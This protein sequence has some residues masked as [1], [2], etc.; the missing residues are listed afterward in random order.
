ML[1]CPSPLAEWDHIFLPKSNAFTIMYRTS[2]FDTTYPTDE[3]AYS[4][5]LWREN[6][7]VVAGTSRTVPMPVRPVAK[8]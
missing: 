2:S 3:C 6:T 7:T 1:A 8:R 4:L 5:Q